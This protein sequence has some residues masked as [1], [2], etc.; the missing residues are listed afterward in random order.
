MARKKLIPLFI[1]L[2]GLALVIAAIVVWLEP[3]AEG[4]VFSVAGGIISLR[5]TNR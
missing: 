2:L 5:K 1:A 4:G 3:P